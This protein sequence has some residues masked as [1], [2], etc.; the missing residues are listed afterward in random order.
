MVERAKILPP[1][2]R[3]AAADPEVMRA[4]LA[5]ESAVAE[6]YAVAID[7]ESAFELLRAQAAEAEEAAALAQER[8]ALEA[9]RAAFEKERAAAAA[10]AEKVAAKEAERA[11][12]E[13]AKAAERAEREAAKQRERAAQTMNSIIGQIGREV[14]R[15]LTRG[16]FGS[17]RR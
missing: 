3:M 14:G 11:E 6:R 1:Q 2:C 9:E 12:R 10:K 4:V 16:I 13:A 7:R 8:A 17:L 5:A 15:Q